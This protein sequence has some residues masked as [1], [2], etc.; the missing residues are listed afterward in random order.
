MCPQSC[1]L[2]TAV[3]LS[4]DNL[5]VTWQWVCMSQYL[6]SHSIRGVLHNLVKSCI[7]H[8]T[9]QIHVT[10]KEGK[11]FRVPLF[12]N[13]PVMYGIQQGS[14]LSHLLLIINVCDFQNKIEDCMQMI[15]QIKY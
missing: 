11:Q 14:V 10:H 9:R 5:A 1:S 12:M 13:L 6:T 2:E 7:M 15:S 8:R 3:V 4:P